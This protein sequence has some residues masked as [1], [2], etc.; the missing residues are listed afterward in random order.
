DTT[1]DQP[2]P[3]ITDY[4]VPPDEPYG[5]AEQLGLN[6]NAD[7]VRRNEAQTNADE[8]IYT[9]FPDQPGGVNP[10]SPAAPRAGAG[11]QEPVKEPTPAAGAAAVGVGLGG[12]TG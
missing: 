10:S 5:G 6:R 8:D 9:D 12:V 1:R 3:L 11:V 4:E 2:K 7:K